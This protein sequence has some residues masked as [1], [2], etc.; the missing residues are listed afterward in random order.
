MATRDKLASSK[1]PNWLQI[2][3]WIQD[4]DAVLLIITGEIIRQE[5]TQNWIAFEVGIAAG[6]D[7]P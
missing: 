3:R 7:P 2:K 6:C 1:D 4:S 5:H